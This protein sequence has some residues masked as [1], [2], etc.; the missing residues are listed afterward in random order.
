[1]KGS[2]LKKIFKVFLDTLLLEALF[3]LTRDPLP[4][5]AAG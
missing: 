1:M 3:S 4:K 5:L 2:N